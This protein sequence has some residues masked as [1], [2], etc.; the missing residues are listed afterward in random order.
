MKYIVTAGGTGGHIYPAISIINKIK[1]MDKK[2]KFL[3]IGTTN[4]MEK[5]IIPNL[6][7]N[8]EGIE[9]YGLSK[10]P[11]K[12]VKFIKGFISGISKCKK[13][14]KDFKPD[15]V[16]G[17]GGYVTAPVVIAAKKLNVPI[18][19]HEQNSV[20]GKA[21]K[22]LTKYV[23]KIC[24]SMK[25]SIEH[26]PEEKTIFTGNPRSE[27]ILKGEKCNKKNYKLDPSKKLVL[28]TTGSLGA[29]TI[30]DKIIELLPSFE[31]KNY[32][33]LI[34]V[35]KDGKAPQ[36]IIKKNHIKNVF[37]VPYID[38]M[39][40]ILKNTDL[41]ISR[42]GATIIAEI[43]ALGIPSILIPSPY[44]A[45]NHQYLNAKYLSDNEACVLI[46]EKDFDKDVLINTIDDILNDKEKYKLLSKNSK[47]LGVMD[48]AT[49]IYEEINKI[50]KTDEKVKK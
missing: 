14:I 30:N 5:D 23:D 22:F 9:M 16:I 21:N 47:T 17:V 42:A 11:V 40:G 18:V 25:S 44:V 12:C 2:A 36:E 13:I 39:A 1:E 4:R 43:T 49:K 20:P 48:S 31:D 37:I 45:N 15:I 7:I 38:D 10:N 29:S 19:L 50:L 3:Y 33:V 46:E 41:I 34:T 28:I 24:V 32:E 35:G 26:F 27:D 8:Y 6:G